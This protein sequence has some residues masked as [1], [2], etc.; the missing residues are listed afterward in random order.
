[1]RKCLWVISCFLAIAVWPVRLAH[2]DAILDLTPATLSTAPG[3]TVQFSGTLTNTGADDLFLNGDVIILS[4]PDLTVDDSP[5][6]INSPPFLLPGGSYVG[7]FLDVTADATTIPGSYSGSYTIQGGADSNTFDNIAEQDF[8]VE[9]SSS[10]VVPE[11]NSATLSTVELSCIVVG[12]FIRR[13]RL[14]TKR[15]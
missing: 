4:Y 13:K 5:F 2:A 11:P 6:F 9:V 15:R 12:S 1:M 7:P 8:T 3:G 10:V 14:K